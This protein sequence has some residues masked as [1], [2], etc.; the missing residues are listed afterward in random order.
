MVRVLSS[1]F[2]AALQATPINPLLLVELDF[3]SNPLRLTTWS[4]NLIF[5]GVTFLGD[6]TILALSAVPESTDPGSRGVTLSLAATPAN[7]A[8]VTTDAFHGRRALVWL[9]LLD[10]AGDL[11]GAHAMFGGTL[12]AARLVADKRLGVVLSLALEDSSR[13][14]LAPPARRYDDAEQQREFPGDTGFR[15]VPSLT[16]FNLRA[17]RV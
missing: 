2:S 13:A 14:V 6:G 9:G 17:A 16:D 4:R 10:S 3:P 5:S 15:Y 8:T 7:K 11:I 1:A 12:E